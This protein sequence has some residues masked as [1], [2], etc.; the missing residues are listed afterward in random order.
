MAADGVALLDGLGIERAH[1][2]GASMGGMIAQTM[3]IEH[4]ERVLTLTS[5]MSTTG[6]SEFGRST[7]GGAR[8]AAHAAA[9]P[10][11]PATS[12]RRS[13]RLIWRSKRYP[14]LAAA[15][16]LAGESY[17]RCYYPA[18]IGRQLA[19]M[20]ASGSRADGLQR[21]RMPTLV[22]HGLDDTLI[23]PSGG[24]RT[25]ALVPDARCCWSRTW[26]T[27]AP[28][29]CGRRSAAR[30][31]S[32]PPAAERRPTRATAGPRPRARSAERA[33][34]L[35]A[36][37]QRV[38]GR[39]AGPGQRADVAHRRASPRTP[40]RCGA[41]RPPRRSRGARAAPAGP[42]AGAA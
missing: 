37:Q 41:R 6:E 10:T 21:L 33:L 5:M 13:A 35:D 26:A 38:V 27:T 29:R 36:A 7:P 30:F 40:R 25:A 12:R 34:A 19:A 1:V 16:E 22:I 24:E 14:D 42:R 15:R 20:I 8:G 2:V 17:D 9:Q 39:R 11:A 28:S 4:P 23:A 18:G 32:T 3:A 31:S